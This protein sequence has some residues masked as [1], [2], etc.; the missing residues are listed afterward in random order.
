MSED[1]N[2]A[3]VRKDAERIITDI[4]A[5]KLTINTIENALRADQPEVM[6]EWDEARAALPR[7]QEEAKVVLRKLG[8]GTHA[9]GGHSI[10]VKSAPVST[11]CDEEGLID[12]ATDR[13]E[14]TDLLDAGVLKYAVVPH[15]I[16][17]LPAKLAAIYGGYL[18]EKLGTP[19]ISLP[20]ELK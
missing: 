18:K 8:S 19:A 20:P 17:R 6:R 9:I 5:Q 16:G 4:A 3:A 14:L 2:L 13:Q 1:K 15:Q 10:Q 7:L 12:R 11:V